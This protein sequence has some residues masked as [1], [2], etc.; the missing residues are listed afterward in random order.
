MPR[1][2]L[3][4]FTLEMAEKIAQRPTIGLKLAKLSVNQSLDA[5]GMW[6]ALQSAFAL[7][8][9]GHTHNRLMH[10]DIVDPAGIDVIRNQA[11]AKRGTGTN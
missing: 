10:G 2:K 7:H 5:Q 6:T 1:D 3:D 11:K 8:Q 9:L 4:S